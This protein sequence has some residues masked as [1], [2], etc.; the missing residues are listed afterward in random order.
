M[1]I[2]GAHGDEW[3][4]S[5][6]RTDRGLFGGVASLSE[7]LAAVEKYDCVSFPIVYQGVGCGKAFGVARLRRAAVHFDSH[8]R[9]VSGEP[10]CYPTCLAAVG[11]TQLTF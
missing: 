4:H 6:S 11:L 8:Q 3:G 5:R 10:H 1:K 9:T 2:L 7:A